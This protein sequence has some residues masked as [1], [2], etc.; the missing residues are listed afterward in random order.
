MKTSDKILTFTALFISCLALTVSIVQTRIMQKQSH[1]A[2]WPRLGSG[3]SWGEDYF[4]FAVTNQGVGP[5]IVN[6][7]EFQFRDSTFSY[8]SGMVNHIMRL[9]KE[10]TGQKVQ[11]SYG[12]SDITE[13]RVIKAAETIEVYKA[14][15]STSVNLAKKYFQ[16]IDVKIDYCSIYEKCWSMK[17]D[18][19]KEIK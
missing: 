19:I 18:D 1:A 16:D 12:Y 10:E 6:D 7:I 14:N 13:G 9:E 3:A 8:I 11:M 15:D 5:A 17:R 4:D 2:V